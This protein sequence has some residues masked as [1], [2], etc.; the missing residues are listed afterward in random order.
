MSK[1]ASSHREN[2]I[3]LQELV[4]EQLKLLLAGVRT[5]L[6][7]L[8]AGILLLTLPISLVG[9][10]IITSKYHTILKMTPLSELIFSIS[11]LTLLTGIYL[12]V[13][14]LAQIRRYHVQIKR[15]EEQMRKS[16][17]TR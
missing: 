3:E 5:S 2:E 9:L 12:I 6:S 16:G 10:L 4:I 14:A 15:L 11:G 1:T 17:P 8:R 7:S 13:R